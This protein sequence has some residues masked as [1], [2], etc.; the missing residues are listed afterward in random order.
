MRSDREI[1]QDVASELRWASDIDPSDIAVKVKD[2][3]VTLTG[4]VRSY[5]L[6][7]KVEALVK[8]IDGVAGLANDLEAGF[9]ALRTRAAGG[10]TLA[11]LGRIRLQLEAGLVQPVNP[12]G[13]RRGSLCR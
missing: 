9:A 12:D 2:G 13:R 11:E 10:A 7:V 6:K 5:L 8:Q 3:V 1:E 4:F